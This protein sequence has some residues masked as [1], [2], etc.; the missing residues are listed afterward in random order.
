MAVSQFIYAVARIRALENNLLD[1][2]TY[3]R[4]LAEDANGVLRLVR[5]TE[6]AEAF[7]DIEQPWDF[8]RGLDNEQNRILTLLEKLTDNDRAIQ[9]LRIGYDFYNL[10]ILMVEKITGETQEQSLCHVGKLMVDDLKKILAEEHPDL[11]DYLQQTYHKAIIAIEKEITTSEVAAMVDREMWKFLQNEYDKLSNEFL[12]QLFQKQIDFVNIRTFLRLKDQVTDQELLAENLIDDGTLGVKFFQELYSEPWDIFF[13]QLQFKNYEDLV[14]KGL[15]S[16]PEDRSLWQYER[17]VDDHLLK[18]LA[19]TK[20]IYFGVE[21][22][23]AYYYFKKIEMMMLRTIFV[24]KIN[25]L[26]DKAI[27]ERLRINH[28]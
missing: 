13:R 16:W 11:P 17:T 14:S 23:I 7:N 6:Y 10:K 5:E 4:L 15:A 19:K 3:E 20:L 12:T 25:G 22:L 1:R 18:L 9:L 21:A 24:G 28:V 2:A 26:P 27:N 8:E